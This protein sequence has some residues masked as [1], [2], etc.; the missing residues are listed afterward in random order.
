[1]NTLPTEIIHHVINFVDPIMI[2][3]SLYFV[4]YNFNEI[5]K[6]Y[7]GRN[8]LDKHTYID[9]QKYL[10]LCLDDNASVNNF[11]FI[12]KFDIDVN[13]DEICNY[14]SSGGNLDCL[15]YAHENGC[16]WTSSTCCNA[17]KNGHLECLQYAHENGCD[18]GML[19]CMRAARNGHLDCL[20]HVYT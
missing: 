6:E 17:T 7:L 15:K 16:E 9:L 19:T 18:W 8:L 1:M 5:S 12:T 14:A 13:Y 2:S 4:N 20:Q 11:D 10:I 3:Y